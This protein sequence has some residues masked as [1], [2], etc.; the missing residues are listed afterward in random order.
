MSFEEEH[1][2]GEKKKRMSKKMFGQAISSNL[3]GKET[4]K[5]HKKFKSS[6]MEH[7]AWMRKRLPKKYA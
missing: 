3:K 5:L 1:G 4:E 6:G 7:E 2:L